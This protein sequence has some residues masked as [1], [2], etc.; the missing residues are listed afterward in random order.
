MKILMNCIF[1]PTENMDNLEK[2]LSAI[3]SVDEFTLLMGKIVFELDPDWKD[4]YL[5][6]KAIRYGKKDIIKS[7]VH[8]RGAPVNRFFSYST[9]VATPLHSAVDLGCPEIVKLLL[10]KGAY[11]GVK[12]YNEETPLVMAAKMGKDQITDLLLSVD[13]RENQTNRE[14]ISHLHIA[15]A[16]NRVDVVKR[17]LQNGA[18]IN[19]PVDSDSLHWPSFTP[20]HFAV[21]FQCSET[22]R[23]LVDCGANIAAKAVNDLT[24][25]HFANTLRN[26][27]IIDIILSAHKYEMTNPVN[28]EGLSHFHIACTRNDPTIVE[29]F[30]Q[31]G[32]DINMEVFSD[33]LNRPLC[34]PIDFAIEYECVDVVKLLLSYDANLN[35]SKCKPIQY[36]HSTAN[37]III[38]LLRSKSKIKKPD[39][40]INKLSDFHVACMKNCSSVKGLLQQGIRMHKPVDVNSSILSTSTTPLHLAVKHKSKLMAKLLLK[41]R[42]DITLA[43]ARGKT[44][45]H[46]AFESNQMNIVDSIL[47]AHSNIHENPIDNEGLSHFHISCSR[48]N[49]HIIKTF[50]ENGVNI[51]C[52]IDSNSAFNPGSTPLHFAVKFNQ[53]EVVKLL[54][55]NGADISAKN[56]IGLAPLDVAIQLGRFAIIDLI[57]SAASQNHID[58]FDDRGFSLLH[59][60]CANNDVISIKNF[61]NSHPNEISKPV[62]WSESLWL[63]CTPLHFAVNFDNTQA[64]ELLLDNGADISVKDDLGDTP[65]HLALNNDA[66]RDNYFAIM[67]TN[68][69]PVGSHGFSHFHVAC[70]VGNVKAVEYFLNH[71]VNVNQPTSE[72][73]FTNTRLGLACQSPLHVAIA[74]NNGCKDVIE[75]LLKNGANINSKDSELNTPLHHTQY[76]SDV[77]V[78]EILLSQG[79]DI[80]GQNMY[81][82]TILVRTCFHVPNHNSAEKVLF[83][84][85]SGADI[86]IED[87]RGA[88]PMEILD[89]WSNNAEDEIKC[90]VSMM[91]H[92]KK[93]KLIDSHISEKNQLYYYALLNTYEDYKEDDFIEQCLK[94]LERM[95]TVKLDNYTNL[96]SILTKSVNKMAWHSENTAF[97]EMV[98]SVDFDERFPIY[99]CLVQIQFEKG[100]VRRPLLETFKVSLRA[101]VSL[102]LPAECTERISQYLSNEDSQN[103]ISVTNVKNFLHQNN[104]AESNCFKIF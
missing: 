1:N 20:L 22:V 49:L 91:R 40:D 44:P 16:R 96:Y 33:S 23:F 28:S 92:L 88:N 24:P 11:V 71:G 14:N 30:I 60:Y 12:N 70:L 18:Q 59:A 52:P 64:A 81:G 103:I 76:N 63:G 68:E 58:S 15:C 26:K 89:S 85:K 86:N 9:H 36:A 47:S 78:L 99:G 62:S 48:E 39:T 79:A 29:R 13:D 57:L 46:V 97:R 102:T 69:N 67:C 82:E 75:L 61:L 37:K 8:Q 50:L 3:N 27:A 53:Y 83:L 41:H 90:G 73:D 6:I 35:G 38:E 21:H 101:L 72:Y 104:P 84:L 2:Q 10:D 98:S 94:E 43:D 25:L 55:Q 42:A 31:Q 56:G 66:Y 7:L 80:N 95:K 51:N 77:K 5:L 87:E 32:V 54:L 4:Y 19:D 74:E 100:L 45:L 65:W 93:L 17:L 34:R